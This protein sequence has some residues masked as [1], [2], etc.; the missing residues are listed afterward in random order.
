[1]GQW[2]RQILKEGEN[3]IREYL[4]KHNNRNKFEV[5]NK[6]DFMKCLNYYRDT[7]KKIFRWC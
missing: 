4:I 6:E 7:I 2:N 5:I 1:M 3:M